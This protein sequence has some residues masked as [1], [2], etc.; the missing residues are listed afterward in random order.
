MIFMLVEME[1]K[2]YL[3]VY[4]CFPWP[5]DISQLSVKDIERLQPEEDSIML[6]TGCID[7]ARQ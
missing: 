2:I 5:I 3:M 4:R 6:V 7:L 1:Q